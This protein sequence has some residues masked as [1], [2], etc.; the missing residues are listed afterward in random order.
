[1][2][3][4]IYAAVLVASASEAVL[5]ARPEPLLGF[6]GLAAVL[7]VKAGYEEGLLRARFGEA[8]DLYAQRVPRLVPVPWS[9]GRRSG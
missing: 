9:G 5:A 4:P 3:H 7:H 8:Y 2:R 1:V 6:L